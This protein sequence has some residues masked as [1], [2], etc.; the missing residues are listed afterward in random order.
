M[1]FGYFLKNIISHILLSIIT[2]PNFF[3]PISYIIL[4]KVVFIYKEY[5]QNSINKT[6]ITQNFEYQNIRRIYNLIKNMNT[7]TGIFV[8][9]NIIIVIQI[10]ICNLC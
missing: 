3:V 6:I 1:V 10:L 9:T 7:I 2:L 8:Y 5:L 4:V